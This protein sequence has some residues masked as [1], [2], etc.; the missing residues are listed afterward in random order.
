MYTAFS[1][2]DYYGPSAPSPGH[3]PTVSLPANR[4][5]AGRGGRPKD[6]SHVHHVP[7]DR[8]DVQLC[9]CSLATTEAADMR[10]WPPH[11]CTTTASESLPSL[12]QVSAHCCPA[13]I[14]QV[15]AGSTLERVQPLVHLRYASRSRL[16]GPHHLAVLARPGVVRAA[17]HPPP[18][19]W[20]Q[21]ALSFTGLLR[22]PGA[23]GLSPAAGY[24]APR[25][26]RERRG[27]G[28][29]PRPRR[30]ALRWW[31]T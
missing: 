31:R 16:P 13:H 9:R 15:G 6:G 28:P 25:G 20:G 3:Q 19:L 21:A 26:A 12:L 4:L 27:T 7:V 14:H 8:I 5:A 29:S 11:R 17:S 10:R 22:Q 18:H 30:G 24:T 23:A 1:C 2:S